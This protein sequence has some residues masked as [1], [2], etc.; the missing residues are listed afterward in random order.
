M[1]SGKT[2]VGIEVARAL[3]LSLSDSDVV[4]TAQTGHTGRQIAERDGVEALHD[5]E[6]RHLLDALGGEPAVVAAAASVLDDPG[7][8][9]AI[10]AVRMV[11]LDVEPAVLVRRVAA[12]S[13]RRPLAD[14]IA[15]LAAMRE[16]RLRAAVAAGAIVIDATI[17]TPAEIAAEIVRLVG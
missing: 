15:E 7:C 3:G 4:I 13:H 10:A 11:F 5:L 14:P 16:R 2:A 12:Q 17:G 9:Q 6:A 8:L 1:A